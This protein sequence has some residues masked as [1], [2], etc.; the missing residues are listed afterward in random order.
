LPGAR[1]R[2]LD[3][4]FWILDERY[5]TPNEIRVDKIEKG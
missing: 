4:G 2:I 3:T 5:L 1:S